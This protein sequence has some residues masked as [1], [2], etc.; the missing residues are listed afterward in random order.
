[1]KT[2]MVF[3]VAGLLA[4]GLVGKAFGVDAFEWTDSF[5]LDSTVTIEATTVKLDGEDGNPVGPYITVRVTRGPLVRGTFSMTA[6]VQTDRSDLVHVRILTATDSD[7]NGQ[8]DPGEWQV[9]ATATP[10]QVGSE[11]IAT[12]SSV[13]VSASQDVYRIEHIWDGF[14][15]S[16]DDFRLSSVTVP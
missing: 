4:L 5:P 15:T 7:G 16:W 2:R 1:M 12:T 10:T 8:I 9:H 6:E 14:G 3:A 13:S 11:W